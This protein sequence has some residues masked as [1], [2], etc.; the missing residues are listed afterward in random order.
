MIT[1]IAPHWSEYIWLEVLGKSSTVQNEL[2][3][4]V[5]AI[6]P[7]LTAAREYVRQTS[8]NITSAEGAQLKRM[9][10]GKATNYDPKQP[11][12]LTIFMA[13]EYPSWQSNVI[14]L[15]RTAFDGMSIDMKA[16]SKQVPKADSKKAMPFIQTL[17]KSLE[18]GVDANTVFERKLAFNEGDVLA[19][20]V[21]GL[22]STVQRCVCVEVISVEQG[23]KK[24]KVVAS[25]GEAGVKEGTELDEL[26]PQAEN[27]VPA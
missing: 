26:P 7:E 20:M 10:K 22:M 9:A 3:P 17:K 4:Q 6:K 1:V 11:K 18:D 2:F 5:P 15:V 24:G 16:L 19:Q 12:K 27:A 25:I 13:T 23:G 14:D 8:G 21:P